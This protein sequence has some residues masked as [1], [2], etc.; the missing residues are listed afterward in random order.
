MRDIIRVM[1]REGRTSITSEPVGHGWLLRKVKF[2]HL[3]RRPAP[4]QL[5]IPSQTW[6]AEAGFIFHTPSVCLLES[7]FVFNREE[8]SAESI[9]MSP[10][11]PLRLNLPLMPSGGGREGGL[12]RPA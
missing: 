10:P 9:L 4:T 7:G 2:C 11:A 1:R 6:L 5:N 8:P 3:L 12:H